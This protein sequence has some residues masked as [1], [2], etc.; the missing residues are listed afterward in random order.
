MMAVGSTIGIRVSRMM[1]D[2]SAI[3][4]DPETSRMVTEKLE[5]AVDAAI[6]GG[7]FAPVIASAWQ[8]W[9]LARLTT[10]TVEAAVRADRR[11]MDELASISGRMALAMHEPFRQRVVANARRLSGFWGFSRA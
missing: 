1:A 4:G 2:P 10:F 8:R 7:T 11:L 9:W 3:H 5:A 6:K